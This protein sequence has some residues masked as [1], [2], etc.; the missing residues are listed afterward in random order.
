MTV[1][2][3]AVPSASLL[4]TAFSLSLSHTHTHTHTHTRARALCTFHY[5]WN[6]FWTLHVY[7]WT[8]MMLFL[9]VNSSLIGAADYFFFFCPVVFFQLQKV[10][11]YL[12]YPPRC[13]VSSVE[14]AVEFTWK[15]Q[16][17]LCSLR[18]LNFLSC[19]PNEVHILCVRCD[20]RNFINSWLK[21]GLK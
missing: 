12:W 2:Q 9:W 11:G 6:I 8:Q 19:L 3:C 14:W 1:E 4:M 21:T 5:S 16:T 20:V 18:V 7:D 13:L 17:N 15:V 10:Y